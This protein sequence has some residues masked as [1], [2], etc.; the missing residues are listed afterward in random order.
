MASGWFVCNMNTGG[1]LRHL[2]SQT[3]KRVASQKSTAK[4]NL[5]RNDMWCELSRTV[6]GR[7]RLTLTSFGFLGRWT[8]SS[9]ISSCFDSFRFHSLKQLSSITSLIFTMHPAAYSGGFLGLVKTTTSTHSLTIIYLESCQCI[10][11]QKNN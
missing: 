6:I 1:D 8:P 9:H 10:L 7:P 4:Q 2:R 11:I 3:Q 5:R